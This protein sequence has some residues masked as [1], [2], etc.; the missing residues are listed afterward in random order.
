MSA[1]SILSLRVGCCQSFHKQIQSLEPPHLICH[2]PA[3]TNL[4]P[5]QT[6]LSFGKDIKIWRGII[7]SGIAVKK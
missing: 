4:L 6:F 7:V 5:V 2:K 1:T 3:E